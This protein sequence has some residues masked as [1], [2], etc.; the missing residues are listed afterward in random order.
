MQMRINSISLCIMNE[1]CFMP[2]LNERLWTII[3]LARRLRIV[4]IKMTQS[5][6]FTKINFG[7]VGEQRYFC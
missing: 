2:V 6:F 3:Q 7:K 1:I 4:L 5:M